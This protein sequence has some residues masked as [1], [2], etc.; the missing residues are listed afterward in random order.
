MA[1]NLKIRSGEEDMTLSAKQIADASVLAAAAYKNSD[2]LLDYLK[3]N[4]AE[5]DALGSDPISA[6]PYAGQELPRPSSLGL[7]ES[8]DSYFGQGFGDSN[9]VFDNLNAQGFV[10]RNDSDAHEIALVFRG[11]DSFAS[12][13]G[14]Q[15]VLDWLDFP[16]H[17]AKF[18]KLIE[19]F[20]QYLNSHPEITTVYVVG[21]SLGAAMVHGYMASHPDTA[22][23]HYF[24]VAVASPGT[25]ASWRDPAPARTADLH[26]AGDTVDLAAY[27]EGIL[28]CSP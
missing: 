10:A 1:C 20:D 11:T 4:L 27:H 7:L 21:H 3:I 17:Y 5:W 25:D 13:D 16:A 8:W 2:A 24:G 14:K 23:R 18:S 12:T 28:T 22:A 26:N 9:F 15:D 6:G 19:A